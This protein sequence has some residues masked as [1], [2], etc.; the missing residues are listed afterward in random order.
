MAVPKK[1]LPMFTQN[2]YRSM[3]E[4][5]GRCMLGLILHMQWGKMCQTKGE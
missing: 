2:I 4:H 3:D 1:I 5:L